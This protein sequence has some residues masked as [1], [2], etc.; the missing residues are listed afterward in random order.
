MFHSFKTNMEFLRKK[1][2][3]WTRR[4]HRRK[5]RMKRKNKTKNKKKGR[6]RRGIIFL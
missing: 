5:M 3:K 1:K 6:L 4:G 2:G